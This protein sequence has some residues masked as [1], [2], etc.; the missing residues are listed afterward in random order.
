ME[1]IASA[2][3]RPARR[4]IPIA[5][6]SGQIVELGRMVLWEGAQEIAFKEA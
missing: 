2:P 1:D 6:E 5:E 3:T 4:V